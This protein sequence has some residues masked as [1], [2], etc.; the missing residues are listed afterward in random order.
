MRSS[1][2]SQTLMF[3]QINRKKK[4]PN[5]NTNHQKTSN[6]KKTTRTNKHLSTTALNENTPHLS[7][8]SYRLDSWF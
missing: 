7:T 4:R 6:K 8:K 5:N 2:L 1:P 3:S